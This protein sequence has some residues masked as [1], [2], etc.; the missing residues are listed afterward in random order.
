[1]RKQSYISLLALVGIMLGPLAFAGEAP[2]APPP[3]P[4]DTDAPIQVNVSIKVVEFQTIKDVE[5][6]L[7]AYFARRNKN[8]TYARTSSGNGAVRTADI[9]F[10]T[11][12]GTRL[13]GIT[14]FLDN[15]RTSY[16]DI[17]VVLQ[18]LVDENRAY[19]LSRPKAMVKVGDPAG[20]II[21]TVR[22]IPYENTTVVGSTTVQATAF[23]DTGVAMTLKVPKVIDDD[24]DW[25]TPDDTYINLNVLAEVKELGSRIVIA[26]DDRLAGGNQITAPVFVSRS[27]TTNVW[28]RQGQVLV[29]GGLYRNTKTKSLE[30]LPWLTQAEDMAVGVAERLIPGNFLGSPFTATIGHREVEEGRR[31]L[32][33]FIKSETWSQPMLVAEEHGFVE[34][35]EE[36]KKLLPSPKDIITDVLEGIADIPQGIAEGISGESPE[37]GSLESE[38]R[39]EEK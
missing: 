35:N 22:Q 25:Y 34:L 14:V 20:T 7:S 33:F 31:E 24:G 13:E 36:A 17:E 37:E 32:V 27:I 10:P 8:R 18:A 15:L 16:G 6:G 38:M 30:T 39:M 26:L 1:M 29:L 28:V 12:A 21:K 23:R 2:P 9:T 3:P 19:I 4:P 11:D 5:T